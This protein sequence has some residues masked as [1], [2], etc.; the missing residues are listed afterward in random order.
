MTIIERR[1]DRK[2]ETKDTVH[3]IGDRRY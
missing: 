2:G 1:I 3:E